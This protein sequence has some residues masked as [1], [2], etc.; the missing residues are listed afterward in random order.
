MIPVDIKCF[1]TDT[2]AT[3]DICTEYDYP[4]RSEIG[5]ITDD[6][7]GVDKAVATEDP[8]GRHVQTE[9]VKCA[10]KKTGRNI[11]HAHTQYKYKF[12]CTQQELYQLESIKDNLKINLA[13]QI[14][15]RAADIKA[16]HTSASAGVT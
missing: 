3:N 15:E 1:Q 7:N 6:P 10:D 13:S 11:H 16:I 9:H 4:E 8:I 2:I 12:S 14:A 5:T